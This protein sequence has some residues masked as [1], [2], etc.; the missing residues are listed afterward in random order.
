MVSEKAFFLTL[1]NLF[2]P[3]SEKI[4]VIVSPVSNANRFQWANYQVNDQYIS[5]LQGATAREIL[6]GYV[7]IAPSG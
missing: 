3:S 2:L 4:I 6:L 1:L 7:L 5:A